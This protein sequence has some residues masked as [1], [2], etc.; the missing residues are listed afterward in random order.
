MSRKQPNRFR[1]LAALGASLLLVSLLPAQETRSMIYGRVLDPQ[2]SAVPGAAVVV[3]NTDTNVV[4]KLT[5]NETGY[6]EANLLLPG[7]Y[8]VSAESAGFKRTVRSGMTLTISTRMEINVTLELGAVSESVSVTAEAPIL[9]TSTVSSGR[10]VDNRTLMDLPVLGNSAIL[11]VKLTPGIQVPGTNNYLGLHSNQ[12]GSGYYTPGNVGGNEWSIDGMPNMG[13]ERRVAYLPY[14]DTLSEFKVETSNF[15]TSV[16]H[17][18]GV[19]IAMMSKAGTNAY[20]GTLTE[21]HWQQRWNGSSFFVRKNYYAN[22]AAAE[23]RGDKALADKLRSEDM[24]TS[25][26]SNNYAAT[27]GGPIV[28]PKLINGK[29]RLFF[30]FAWNGFK[31]V[32]SEDATNI[33]RTIPGLA[34]REG[35]FSRLLQVDN[36]GRYRIYD[37]LSVRPDP[38][39]RD[40]YIRDPLPGNIVPRSRFINPVYDAYVKLLPTPNNEPTDPRREPRNN[41]LAIATPYDWDY[42]AYTNRVDF[43]A[44]DRHRFFGRWSWNNFQ[45][46]RGDWT[47]ESAR[48]LNTN[49]LNRH[50]VGAT[51]DWVF[52]KSAST[53]FD[54]ALAANE[55][56]S[57]TKFSVPLQYN[58]AKMGLP[59][60][61][62]QRAG[63]QQ[64]IP[65]MEFSGYQTLGRGWPTFTR[66]RMLTG[67][68]DISHVRGRHTLRGGFDARGHF[69]TGGGGGNITGT[70]SFSNNYTRKYD[71][72][73]EPSGDYGHSWAAFIMGIPNGISIPRN[74]TYATN[75]PYYAWYVQD[76]WRLTSKLSL[77]LGLRLEYELGPT[78]RYN[79]AIAYFDYG[80]KLPIT[81]AAQA[82]YAR[83]PVPERAAST[84]VVQGG[85][86]YTGVGGVSRRLI[87]NELNWLPRASLAY[88]MNDKTV[89]R[90]GYGLFF[91]TINVLNQGIDQAG[92]SRSTGTTV[93]TNFGVNWL[94]GD[95]KNGVSSLRDPFPVRADRTRFNEPTRDAL[96]LMARVGRGWSFNDFNTRHA[97]MQRVRVGL[98][99]QITTNQVV[100][101]AYAGSFADRVPLAKSQS[102]LPEKY[103][104]DGLKRN[105]AVAS[106]MNANVTNPFNINNFAD[107]RTSLPL[108]YQDMSTQGFFTSSIIGKNRLLRDFPHMNGLTKSTVPD[109]AMRSHAL[110]VTFER[111]FSKGVSMNVGYTRLKARERDYYANEFDPLPSWQTTN[112]GRPHRFIATSIIELPFGRGRALLQH[113]P[114]SWIV[115]GWQ[116]GVTYEFQPGSL[117]GWGSTVF[118]YGQSLEDIRKGERT[119]DRWFNTG[120]F[121]TNSAKTATSYH[122]RVFPTRLEGVRS[123]M[124]NQWNSN[125]QR[126]FKIRERVTFQ[127]RM[128]A[129]NTFNRAQMSGPSTSPNSTDFGRITSQS[130]ATNRWIQIQSRIRF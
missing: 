116:L 31:D 21:Q 83:N 60:Y 72:S 6:Y 26:R 86:L 112:D 62:D 16:G 74:E 71:D 69:R 79:R 34:D 124:L 38:A 44:S 106:N 41:Y 47:Y 87:K 96:G 105:D 117:L 129:I 100:E 108:V 50:N 14:S 89:L 24:Q 13:D 1:T 94:V 77:N 19:N 37:P 115:G 28:I 80:A 57:G 123:D 63:N 43:Q 53:V 4:T 54:L 17:T 95:P 65:T 90:G 12:G 107:F 102:P 52:S 91:D 121:E 42:T 49:G 84:F 93:T 110:E 35:N 55:F 11:L 92:Y 22:I 120:N 76:N 119:L 82:A 101:V 23:A 126:D 67:K 85:S 66:Y 73:L 2:G 25:G 81:D 40:H 113:G 36:P 111:R 78:E 3:T 128:D 127:L 59:A 48:G 114:L 32:K 118:Y 75:N 61:I 104:A 98:Q 30:F 88:Q 18:T 51:A 10:V 109:G 103:W 68:M 122:R 20:H 70:Y 58:A 125:I 39:R 5:T 99:R 130:S 56:K 29:D 97:R 46:D 9:D 27:I 45:E 33:N 8:Q 7:S 64:I 15:D